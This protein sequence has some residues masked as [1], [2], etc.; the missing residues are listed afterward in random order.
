ARVGG[1]FLVRQADDLPGLDVDLVDVRA[2][3]LLAQV[4]VGVVDPPGVE[5]HVR[6]GDR[7]LAAADEHL[8]FAAGAERHQTVAG[9]DVG[10]V[11]DLRPGRRPRLAVVPGDEARG[12]DVNDVVVEFDGAV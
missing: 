5:R 12:A 7:A 10:R 8:L 3:A 9:V 1:R 11:A 4:E 2:G 6:V